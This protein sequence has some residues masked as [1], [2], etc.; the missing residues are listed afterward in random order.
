[1][2]VLQKVF[3]LEDKFLISNTNKHEGVLL[4]DEILMGG[5]FGQL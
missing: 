3:L 1:M 2:Y 5:N 4:L